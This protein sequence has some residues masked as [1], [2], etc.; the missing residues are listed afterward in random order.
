MGTRH[1]LEK[2][3]VDLVDLETWIK[4]YMDKFSHSSIARDPNTNGVHQVS[5]RMLHGLRRER[6]FYQGVE[7]VVDKYWDT[8]FE[9]DTMALNV[10]RAQTDLCQNLPCCACLRAE[11]DDSML[12]CSEL[13]GAAYM[14]S[15]LMDSSLNLS[16]FVPAMWD[17]TRKLCLKPG[18]EL[19]VEHT[20]FGP[21]S[22]EQRQALGYLDIDKRSNT[23]SH[24]GAGGFFG[25]D[26]S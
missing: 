20:C 4:D 8:D 17:T 18:V 25:V 6:D 11:E 3:G 5:V 14:A 15:G 22:L 19:G 2:G 26:V 10:M 23:S 12:F 21:A 1:A 7:H 13:V 16:E 9:T 24:M